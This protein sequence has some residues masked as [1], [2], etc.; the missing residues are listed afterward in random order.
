MNRIS[1]ISNSRDMLCNAII[2][3]CLG[4]YNSLYAFSYYVITEGWF[5]EFAKLVRNGYVPHSDYHMLISPAYTLLIAS[6][7]YAFGEGFFALRV[8]GVIVTISIG[9]ALFHLLRGFLGRLPAF[10]ASIFGTIYYQSGNAYF[11]YD[12]T[13]LMSLSMLLGAVFAINAFVK[14]NRQP[15]EEIPIHRMFFTSGLF[16]GLTVALKH[17][18]GLTMVA[19]FGALCVVLAI[20]IG[21]L[22]CSALYFC[23]AFSGFL[24]PLTVLIAWVA[25]AGGLQNMIQD[26]FVDAA[27]AKG[28]LSAIFTNWIVGFFIPFDSYTFWT[29]DLMKRLFFLTLL[30]CA[31][32]LP[33]FIYMQKK[34]GMLKINISNG[35]GFS[36]T[37]SSLKDAL[38][39]NEVKYIFT[40]A[41]LLLLLIINVY[42]N[43]FFGR[44]L[45]DRVSAVSKPILILASVNLY[46][47]GTIFSFAYAL[48]KPSDRSIKFALILA[49]GLGMTFGNGTSAGLSEISAFVGYSLWIGLFFRFFLPFGVGAI[50]ILVCSIA[51]SS[52]WVDTRYH[53]PY[54]W[55]GVTAADVRLS[56]CAELGGIFKGICLAPQQAL[57]LEQ[58]TSIILENTNDQDPIFV[59]PH[60]PVFYMTAN[61]KPFDGAVVSWFDFMSDRQASNVANHLIASPPKIIV[62]A[63]LDEEVP[64]A[65]ERL[66]RS[67]ELSGQREIIRAFEKLEK[68]NIRCRIADMHDVNGLEIIILGICR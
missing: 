48:Y 40:F 31:F 52:Y 25:Y 61:R 47:Y 20:R 68:D 45:A 7:Q 19:V 51:L 22:R 33:V 13:Q 14:W 55:W 15:D 67:G 42:S 41:F 23:S 46:V 38:Y 16:F 59:Y 4:F 56:Q 49:C 39:R 8:L 50:P 11:G 58:I 1:N 29:A 54:H 27:S 6:M 28:G 17:S 43:T 12:F 30:S 18:N 62:Y 24:L 5:S 44:E 32:S 34:S 35:F 64:K 36:D 10:F 21:G 65:H 3:L 57:D 63:N 53:S 9:L 2:A 37:Y 26:L 60:M 66:F